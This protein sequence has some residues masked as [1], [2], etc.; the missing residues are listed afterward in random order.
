MPTYFMIMILLVGIT[1][2]I[3]YWQNNLVPGLGVN[4]GQLTSLGKRP[5]DL[6]TQTDQN[7]KQAL[8]WPFKDS[9]PQTMAAIVAAI[10]RYGGGTIKSKSDTYLY[11]VFT[12]PLMRFND[13]AEFWLDTDQKLVHFR[14][15]SRVGYSDMGLN[16]R[17]FEQLTDFYNQQ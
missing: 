13:D 10:E 9:L 6:S 12:T 3:I 15:A 7:D 17:R 4:D 14:S 5:N 1:G 2:G 11:V 8:P 16:R